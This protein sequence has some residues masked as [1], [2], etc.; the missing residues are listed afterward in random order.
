MV[1]YTSAVIEAIFNVIMEFIGEVVLGGIVRLFSR[2]KKV[3]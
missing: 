3:E 1:C 2:K